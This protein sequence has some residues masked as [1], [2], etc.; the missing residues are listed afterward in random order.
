MIAPVEITRDYRLD[1]YRGLALWL[2]FLAHVP[3]T[4]IN[5]LTPWNYG[6]SDAAEAFVFVSGYAN[7]FVY[8]RVMRQRG[9]LIA[10]AQVWRRTFE[11]YVAQMFLFMLFIG[12]IAW[13][14]RGS[15]AFDDAMNIRVFYEHPDEAILAVLQLR[16]MPVNMDV[17]PVY[18][19]L[20]IISPLL[21]W[22][23]WRI[24]GVA[25][26]IAGALYLLANLSG[27]NLPAYPRA[28]WYFNPF[29][30]QLVFVLGAWCGVGAADWVWSLLPGH[31]D[32]GQSIGPARLAALE[33]AAVTL[34]HSMWTAFT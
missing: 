33:I 20:L 27:L 29:A 5:K 30:W 13:L 3:G 12:E 7:A 8:G 1:L 25:L 16:F 28:Y 2:I 31:G 19:V 22:L 10:A 17:L 18:I 9:F 4:I 6:F 14:S 23:L 26:A 21:L 15:H 34:T 32:R 11:I 24:P